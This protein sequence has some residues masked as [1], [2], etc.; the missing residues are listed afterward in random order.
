MPLPVNIESL[1]DNQKEGK[2]YGMKVFP[3]KK[4]SPNW[5]PFSDRGHP[6]PKE[7]YDS[8]AK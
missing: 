8:D 7:P 2:L 1:I 4:E 3:N 6:N 5:Q